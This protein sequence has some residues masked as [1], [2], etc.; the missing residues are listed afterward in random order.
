MKNIMIQNHLISICIPTCNGEK[1]LKETLKSVS[2]QTYRNFEVIISDNLSSDKTLDIVNLWKELQDFPVY[3]F[4]NSNLGIGSN[5]NYCIE[6]SNGK[7]IKFLFQ[8]DLMESDCLRK[9]ILFFEQHQNIKFLASKRNF[10]DS[11]EVSNSE[12]AK[13]WIKKYENLQSKFMNDDQPYH[14]IT[15][16]IFKEDYFFH[17]PTNKI[18]EPSAVMFEKSIIKKIG[19][20]NTKLKQILDLEY[21]YRVLINYDIAILNEHLITFRIH[22]SQE[23][24][25]NRTKKVS[26]Y[27]DYQKF[28]DNKLFWY[29][30]NS[31]KL[32]IMEK[33]FSFFKF[34]RHLNGRLRK[35]I[36]FK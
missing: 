16:K 28:I 6:K 24:N 11:T 5:W 4:S 22:D 32:S 7:Y 34:L 23:T 33:R 8:D 30:N 17:S 29:V 31:R 12:T 26:E 18:G 13:N 21:W 14:I 20:F 15:K 1:F 9:M 2:E 10:L 19:Y 27:S 3:V 35:M 36:N 25:V